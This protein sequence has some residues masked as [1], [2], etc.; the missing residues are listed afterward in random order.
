MAKKSDPAGQFD[1]FAHLPSVPSVRVPRLEPGNGLSGDA[2]MARICE[3]L[4]KA[5]VRDWASRIVVEE[6]RTGSPTE[7]LSFAGTTADARRI[8][9]YLALVGE[10]DSASIRET[11]GL[12]KMRVYRAVSPLVA[13]GRLIAKGQSRQ[14][15]YSLSAAE[16]AKAGRN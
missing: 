16:A 9:S 12:S 2:R 11:L 15:C 4:S 5:V 13:A 3:L 10:A 6:P 8:L 7:S 14:T 1:S